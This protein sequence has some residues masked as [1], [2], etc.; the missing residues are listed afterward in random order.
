MDE[1]FPQFFLFDGGL[2]GAKG[3]GFR[4]P[5]APAKILHLNTARKEGVVGGD[6]KCMH[7]VDTLLFFDGKNLPER[8]VDMVQPMPRL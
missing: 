2:F 3:G 6:F 8:A 4:K 7:G 1:G 5:R